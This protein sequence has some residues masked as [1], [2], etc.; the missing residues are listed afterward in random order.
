MSMWGTG[1]SVAPSR[2]IASQSPAGQWMRENGITVE[3]IRKFKGKEDHELIRGINSPTSRQRS[4]VQHRAK[5][6]GA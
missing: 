4:H 3:R 6:A 1:A 2:R 5:P